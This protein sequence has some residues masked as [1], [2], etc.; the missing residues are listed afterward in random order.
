MYTHT[1]TGFN[2]ILKQGCW[3]GH[4]A[5]V[6]VLASFSSQQKC[7]HTDVLQL[8]FTLTHLHNHVL[9]VL[10]GAHL[11]PHCYTQPH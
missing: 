1:A 11:Y 6:C 5:Y 3:C 8:G 9:Y 2:K 10:V 7:K 4:E